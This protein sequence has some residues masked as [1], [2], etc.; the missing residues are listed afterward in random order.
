MHHSPPFGRWIVFFVRF[1]FIYQAICKPMK[2][3]LSDIDNELERAV[4]LAIYDSRVQRQR[5]SLAR[6]V[7][8]LKH[9]LRGLFYIWPVYLVFIALLLLPVSGSRLVFLF[10][11]MPGLL[12]WSTIYIKGA[13]D[14]YCQYVRGH[15]MEKGFIMTIFRQ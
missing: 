11:L 7:L 1:E 8:I 5:R 4:F 15:L 12:V 9:I 13:Q 6:V 2:R 10:V 14:D 3:D